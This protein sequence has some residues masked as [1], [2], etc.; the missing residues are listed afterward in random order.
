VIE[1]GGPRG[2]A[3]S[4]KKWVLTRICLKTK[5]K[6]SIKKKRGTQKGQKRNCQ[7]FEKSGHVKVKMKKVHWAAENWKGVPIMK[8]VTNRETQI[9]A[10]RV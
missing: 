7:F 1:Q 3:Y 8:E 9:G 10:E 4:C 6:K 5:K 2:R